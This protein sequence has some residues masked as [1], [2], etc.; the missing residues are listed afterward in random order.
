[1]QKMAQISRPELELCKMGTKGEHRPRHIFLATSPL[2][3]KKLPH[4]NLPGLTLR[5]S[6]PEKRATST[7]VC[8]PGQTAHGKSDPRKML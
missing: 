5:E 3:K 6:G 4:K 7:P 8:L 2:L 1:M